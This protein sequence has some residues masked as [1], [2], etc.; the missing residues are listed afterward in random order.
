MTKGHWWIGK[1]LPFLSFTP[2]QT[3]P[4]SPRP[5]WRQNSSHYLGGWTWQMP[6][7]NREP[8]SQKSLPFLCPNENIHDFKLRIKICWITIK[9]CTFHKYLRNKIWKQQRHP[10]NTP[11]YNLKT[12]RNEIKKSKQA[13]NKIESWKYKERAVK[14]R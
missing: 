13:D 2:N 1:S 9:I 6:S 8:F 14:H 3:I 5:A 4:R 7:D 11:E 10:T 12:R